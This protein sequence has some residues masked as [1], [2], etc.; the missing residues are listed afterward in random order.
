MRYG[1]YT[2]GLVSG[3]LEYGFTFGEP[4]SEE[5]ANS[6]GPCEIGDSE[7]DVVLGV[8]FSNNAAQL[9]AAWAKYR[10]VAEAII[11]AAAKQQGEEK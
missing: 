3:G 1:T 11:E 5:A 6:T 10:W 9:E 8:T 2:C 4:G 7:F